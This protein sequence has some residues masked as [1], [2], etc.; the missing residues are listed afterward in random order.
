MYIYIYIIFLVIIVVCSYMCASK[1]IKFPWIRKNL[2]VIIII[3]KEI[4]SCC[5]FFLNYFVNKN[6]FI[7]YLTFFKSNLVV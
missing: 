5:C 2:V 6:E 3:S 7:I 1:D 4:K